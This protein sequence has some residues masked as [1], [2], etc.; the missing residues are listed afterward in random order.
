MRPPPEFRPSSCAILSWSIKMTDS[1]IGPLDPIR[2][3][4]DESEVY[5]SLKREWLS[6]GK[7]RNFL[8]R[9]VT[10]M[11]ITDVS[12]VCFVPTRSYSDVDSMYDDNSFRG[13]LG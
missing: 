4:P 5:F 7:P 11:Q 9:G 10:W 8:F 3:D 2:H 12:G 1:N 6:T 13:V